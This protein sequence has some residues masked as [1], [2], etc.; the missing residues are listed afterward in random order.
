VVKIY[1]AQESDMPRV[2]AMGMV[3]MAT[4]PFGS[5]HGGAP[6]R[7]TAAIKICLTTGVVLLAAESGKV[8][9]MLCIYTIEHP[10]TGELC[11]EELAWWVD[12]EHKS[13]LAGPKLLRAGIVWAR[14]IGVECLKMSALAE[15]R[16]GLFLEHQGFV[17]AETSYVLRF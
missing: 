2:L 6:D 9:G 14:Q 7:L 1:V 10:L 11:A 13:L 17:K 12:P 16:V 4:R 5:T 15:T 8:F 3:F